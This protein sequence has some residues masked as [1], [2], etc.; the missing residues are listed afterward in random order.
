MSN[1]TVVGS[2]NVGAI[3]ANVLAVTEVAHEVVLIDIQE[4]IAEG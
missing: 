4:G 2:G 3:C 1:A